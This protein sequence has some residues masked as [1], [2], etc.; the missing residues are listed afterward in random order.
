[1]KMELFLAKNEE[2]TTKDGEYR[3]YWADPFVQRCGK[4]SPLSLAAG[5]AHV[6]S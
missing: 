4:A 3:I 6:P 5:Q 1:M 2:G